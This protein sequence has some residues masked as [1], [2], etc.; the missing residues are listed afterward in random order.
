M[1]TTP[2][3][4]VFFPEG[5]FGP[6]NNLIGIAHILRQRGARCVFVVEES[7]AGTLEA[8]GF[9]EQSMRLKPKAEI[10]EE[11]GQYWKDFIRETAPRF[12][13]STLDQIE[14]LTK[15]IWVELIDGSR[16]VDDRLAEIF[17]AL[18]PDA[19]VQD[20]VIAFPAVL[21]SGLPWAR[22]ISCNPLE[23]GDPAIAPAYS[24]LPA[25]D[26]FGWDVF[27]QAYNAAIAGIHAEFDAFGRA[28]GCPPLP[29]STFMFES[30]YLNMYVYPAE[31]DYERA[32][33]LNPTWHRLDSCVRATDARFTLPRR[34][35]D[36]P[37][38][39][40]YASLGSLGAAD[41]GLMRHLI[42]VL[43]RSKH[44]TIISMG[45]QLGQIP[46][47][48]NMHGEQFLP[49]P[50]ILPLVDLVV[51]HGGN[52][53]VTECFYFGKPMVVLPLFWDQHDNAQRMQEL[54]FGIRFSGADFDEQSFLDAIDRLLADRAL[55]DRM[56]AISAR[57][58]ADPGTIKAAGLIER[59]AREKRPILRM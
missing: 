43:E 28:H 6:T 18:R 29:E 24:G 9:E 48:E 12:R 2:S 19:I 40:L 26:R 56:A 46:L 39:L 34:L 31:A 55:G 25:T 42:D 47:P 3:T 38:K 45:P 54:G 4:I 11:P 33:P 15:P 7:F 13:E 22:I 59:L 36:G 52:N 51:T 49:Q 10:E 53:T 20:N 44:R 37:G 17:D 23:M 50:S 57:L 27:R 21:R 5:A 32:R 1:P 16:Y 8:Q 58:Q 35:R 14:S 30:P 41:G